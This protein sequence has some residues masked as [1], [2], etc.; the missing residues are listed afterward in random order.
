MKRI[1]R[2]IRVANNSRCEQFLR[3]SIDSSIFSLMG[4]FGI[5]LPIGYEFIDVE[6]R[7]IL[8]EMFAQKDIDSRIVER[9]NAMPNSIVWC[10]NIID[11]DIVDDSSSI[12]IVKKI[13]TEVCVC[14]YLFYTSFQGRYESIIVADNNRSVRRSYQQ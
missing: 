12:P 9:A 10:R 2:E 14:F 13:E 7:T 5:M 4:M 3:T 8:N 1:E 11:Y 6:F